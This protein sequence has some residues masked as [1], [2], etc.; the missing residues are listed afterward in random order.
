MASVC[1]G[2]LALMDAGVPI[3]R[4]VA[5]ISIGGVHKG[6]QRILITDIIGEEDHFGD[7]DFKVSGTQRGIT[8]IQLDLKERVITQ[9]GFVRGRE[10]GVIII[11]SF[12]DLGVGLGIMFPFKSQPRRGDMLLA[13]IDH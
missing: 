6:D 11:S 5:G 4:P 7:M 2:T 12:R 8:G 1:G 13:R 10:V 3:L 9:E